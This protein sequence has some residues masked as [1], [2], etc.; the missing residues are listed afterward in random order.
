MKKRNKIRFYCLTGLMILTSLLLQCRFGSENKDTI[1]TKFKK[2]KNLNPKEWQCYDVENNKIC[3]PSKWS[4]VKQDVGLFFASLNNDKNTYFGIIKTDS[5]DIEEYLKMGYKESL[6]DSSEIFIGYTLKKITFKDKA[7]YYGEYFTTI[8]K[9]EYFTYAMGFE[10]ERFMYDV[11]LKLKKVDSPKYKD[12]FKNI[13][14][15][16]RINGKLVFDEHDEIIKIDTID[17]SSL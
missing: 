13:L 10:Q 5:L 15:N 2:G 6:K 14:F 9:T 3:I 16:F 11:G 7:A 1:E 4:F 17:L 12:T 8:D